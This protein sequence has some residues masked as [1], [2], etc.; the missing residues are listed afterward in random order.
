MAIPYTTENMTTGPFT[1]NATPVR[2][3]SRPK[4]MIGPLHIQCN[5]H[6]DPK[7]LKQLLDDV[8]SWPHIESTPAGAVLVYTPKDPEELSVCYSLFAQAY[9]FACKLGH[10][11][12]LNLS[13][14]WSLL[15]WPRSPRQIPL[16]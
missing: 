8:L 12:A 2:K 4:T 10:R 7:Y 3:G 15:A 16:F 9:H 6:G 13:S 11:A 14:R 1:S 5:G